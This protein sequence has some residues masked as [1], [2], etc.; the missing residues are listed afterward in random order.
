MEFSQ[1]LLKQDK[2]AVYVLLIIGYD[3]VFSVKYLEKHGGT[4]NAKD[5][6]WE[7]YTL[8]KGSLMVC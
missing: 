4:P 7:P 2:Q 3:P 1:K 6:I 8:Y 5:K